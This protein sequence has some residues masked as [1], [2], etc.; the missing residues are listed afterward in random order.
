MP[1][2]T[3]KEELEET[4]VKTRVKLRLIRYLMDHDIEFIATETSGGCVSV[5]VLVPMDGCL[6]L[7]PKDFPS[8]EAIDNILN[9]VRA[10]LVQ[11]DATDVRNGVSKAARITTVLLARLWG[12][13][14][15][16]DELGYTDEFLEEVRKFSD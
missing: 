13:G 5:E 6:D 11:K 12:Y 9:G 16:L 4:K 10:I 3:F 8:D 2:K 7:N 1:E 15:L 14:D